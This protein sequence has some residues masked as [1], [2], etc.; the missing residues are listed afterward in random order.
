MKKIILLLSASVVLFSCNKTSYTISGTAKGIENGKTIIL[1]SQD[2]KL[3]VI[4][5]DTV[6][7]ENG[8]FEIEGKTT[9]PSFHTLQVEGVQGKVP[10]ILENG[11]IK[12]VINKDS[13]H[14]SKVS[15]TYNNDEYVKF[16]DEITLV[17]K[18]LIDF[19]TKNMQAMNAA[20]Q[21]KDTIV[22]NS[23]MKEFTKIQEEVGVASKAKYVTYAETHPKAFISALIIQGMLNDP[24][25]DVAKSEK[26]YNSLEESLKKTKP[27]IAIKAKLAELKTPA[28]GAAPVAPAPAAEAK[29]RTDFSG[30]N[31]QGKVISLKEN[32]GKVTIVDF[33]ASWCG[34]CRQE[35]PNV[36]AIYKELHSKGLNIIG[37]SLDKDAKAWKDAI[38]KDKLTWNHVS[39]LKF[40]DEPIAAQYKVESIP[41][42]FILDASGNV[43]AK[44]L[45]GD[46][47]R[48]KVIE[49][50]A[51]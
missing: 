37:V 6:K 3:G 50:L 14:K 25:A 7:V 48:A 47:L 19:Q 34:P 15:G 45:R 5:I 28:V 12:V 49:L 29:W 16:N 23:L 24:T 20:Q 4:A 40:W 43:V 46:A 18:R 26:L 44:D 8:K 51:K 10:L 2:D 22:I 30:P 11:D 38:A 9:E 31:P 41:A 33:W 42:T 39:N 27:G 21:S 13:I 35:N 1:E 36:V 32:L 17:Q